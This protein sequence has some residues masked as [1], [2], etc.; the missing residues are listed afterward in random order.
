MSY[1][2]SNF[3]C[4]FDC[5]NCNNPKSK[6]GRLCIAPG[7][8]K[9]G[10]FEV[11]LYSRRHYLWR[12]G[13]TFVWSALGTTGLSRVQVSAII[14]QSKKTKHV[15]ETTQSTWLKTTTR[16]TGETSSASARRAARRVCRCSSTFPRSSRC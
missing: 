15:Q 4:F 1:N 8:F 2:S 9:V 3:N 11:V 5:F 13:G 16:R 12:P 10:S 7:G 14:S 6:V